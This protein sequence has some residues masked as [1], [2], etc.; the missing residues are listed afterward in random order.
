MGLTGRTGEQF[1]MSSQEE[2]QLRYS[3][4]FRQD[5]RS[6]GVFSEEEAKTE[7]QSYIN[8]LLGI[9]DKLGNKDLL[10]TV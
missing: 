1:A 3:Y 2:T 8:E 7:V 10:S 4:R 6:P 9:K 5:A